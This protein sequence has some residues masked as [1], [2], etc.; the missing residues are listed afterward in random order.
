MGRELIEAYP[1]FK[2]TLLEAEGYLKEFGST[3]SVIGKLR[4]EPLR[5]VQD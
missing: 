4:I 3:W 2:N 5:D 1:I